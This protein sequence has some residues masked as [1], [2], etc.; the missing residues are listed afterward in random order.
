MGGAMLDHNLQVDDCMLSE[1]EL[2]VLKLIATGKDTRRIVSLLKIEECTVRFH[3]KS[4]LDRLN[5]STRAAAVYYAV[6]RGWIT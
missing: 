3:V 1:R 5:V 4:I 2:E 6:K